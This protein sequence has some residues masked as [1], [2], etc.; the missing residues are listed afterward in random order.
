MIIESGI[1]DVLE[2]LLLRIDPME[3]GVSAAALRQEVDCRLNQQNKIAAFGG[4]ILIMHTAN[5]GLV[6]AEHAQKLFSWAG[7]TDKKIE[8]FPQGDHNSIMMVNA[9]AYFDLVG[10]FLEKI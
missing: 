6:D 7:T 1:A 8:I 3:L 5:D 4:P 10:K 9:D 2:R